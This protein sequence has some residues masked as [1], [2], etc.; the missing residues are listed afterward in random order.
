MIKNWTRV[1]NSNWDTKKNPDIDNVAVFRHANGK[2]I[3]I[4][5]LTQS[6]RD[7]MRKLTG[8]VVFVHAIYAVN[9]YENT[10]GKNISALQSWKQAL[11][12]AKGFMRKHP[13][14]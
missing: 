6:G 9:F 1:E 10:T 11:K 13:R 12:T 4:S 8:K 3:I 2:E 14:G 5:R 7:T